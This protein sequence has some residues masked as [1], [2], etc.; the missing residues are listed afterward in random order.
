MGDNTLKPWLLAASIA[1][2]LV[3][4]VADSAGLGRLAVLSALG[5]P[6][7]AEIE[8]LA[9]Q[10]GESIAAK[11]ASVDTYQQANLQFNPAL[12]GTRVTVEKR[13][14][15]QLFLK[16]TT[17]K[18]VSEPFV[19][20][21]VELN[22]EHGRV[23]RQYT[24]LLD[25]PGYGRAAADIAPPAASVAVRPAPAVAAAPAA[26]AEPAA[27][28]EATAEAADAA[29]PL[30][31]A[32]ET[33][34][35]PAAASAPEPA[36]A[37][38]PAAEPASV[39]P[40]RSSG[41]IAAAPAASAPSA[42]KEYGPVKPGDTLTRIARSVQPAGASL[43]QTLVGLFRH[44]PDAFIKKNMN[45]VKSGKILRIPDASEITSVAQGE[46]A[47]E[48]HVQ[49]AD[50]NALRGKLADQAAS[51][52]EEG[53][54]TSGRIG[55]ARVAEPG[56]SEARDTVRLSKG[57]SPS[58]KTGRTGNAA[59]RVRALEEEAVA[60]E[61]A[62]VEANERIAQLEK[63]IKDMQ[64]LVELK[65]SGMATAQQQ[66]DK[67]PAKP[68]VSPRT[69]IPTAA[70]IEPEKKAETAHTPAAS[71]AKGTI[72]PSGATK[73]PTADDSKAAA[74]Q[75]KPATVAK[76]KAATPP[77]ADSEDLLETIMNEPLYLAAGGAAILLGGLGVAMV[78]RR[79][80]SDDELKDDDDVV[81]IPPKF[82]PSA[83]ATAGAAGAT[84]AA[85]AASVAPASEPVDEDHEQVEASADDDDS[86][87]GA[88]EEDMQSHFRH[89]AE[90]PAPANTAEPVA[91]HRTE[92]PVAAQPAFSDFNL[93]TTPARPT[94]PD[95]RVAQQSA[96][97][98]EPAE[99]VVRD[100]G[101]G[102]GAPAVASMQTAGSS[103]A[104]DLSSVDFNLDALPAIDGAADTALADRVDTAPDAA[105]HEFKLDD[106]DLSFGEQPGGRDAVKDDH[107]YDVQQK[108]DLAKAYE[109]M[110]DK[111]G[112]R[113]ILQEVVKEGDTEQQAQAKTLLESL[114]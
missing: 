35:E 69:E 17:P 100:F 67:S 63:T 2:L 91:H 80:K 68:S 32:P 9:V 19:E 10:K 113:D 46:A 53:S 41:R 81:K 55:G 61:K 6:L 49:I 99:V 28:Q 102:T 64:R 70:V 3:P 42:D 37:S 29:T 88:H 74:A 13:P 22:S 48:I 21:V 26:A 58:G 5:Q 52:R 95:L 30:A 108:F 105:M 78:R 38:A 40:S 72:E 62:L 56:A 20:L 50:F 97:E 47:Q 93:D 11:L 27:S 98:D 59:D 114:S 54:V 94:A 90:A 92:E 14:N 110:G 86:A 25:P 104:R 87:D 66:T 71:T 101:L 112:A 15:G 82:G 36:T 16:A 60:R 85:S 73:A 24:I 31:A 33:A 4:C 96:P 109:E 57:E 103:A 44:N 83:A 84:A 7:N 39:P 8:L 23:T 65:S 18:P 107:W 34:P 111:D 51:A 43:E 89:A 12:I 79:R 1:A 77:P 106:L 45:L 76:A 75:P